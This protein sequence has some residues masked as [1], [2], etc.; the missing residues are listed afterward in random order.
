MRAWA[1]ACVFAS[2]YRDYVHIRQLLWSVGREGGIAICVA[3]TPLPSSQLHVC[4][5]VRVHV[6][7]RLLNLKFLIDDVHVFDVS[8]SQAICG[9][10]T[11]WMISINW[12]VALV[13]V[14]PFWFEPGK[15]FKSVGNGTGQ[16]IEVPTISSIGE[17]GLAIAVITPLS[18]LTMTALYALVIR[19]LKII[20][21]NPVGAR[22]I[23]HNI[24]HVQD[25]AT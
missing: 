12:V 8:L 10:A 3:P 22:A 20:N 1:R 6:G 15:E 7:L 24:L 2:A 13:S 17:Y 9:L 23:A 18:A 14:M 21:N 4:I 5:P 19:R 16:H 11:N 25:A